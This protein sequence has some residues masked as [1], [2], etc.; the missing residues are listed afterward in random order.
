MSNLILSPSSAAKDMSD[1]DNRFVAEVWLNGR[2]LGK[3]YG[4]SK[5][6]SQQ[7]AAKSAFLALTD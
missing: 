1:L 5:K 3:G 6:A 7:A 4:R 2:C